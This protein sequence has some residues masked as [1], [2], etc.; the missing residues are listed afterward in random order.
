MD[1]NDESNW[2][3]VERLGSYQ[4]RE[5]VPLDKH[6]QGELYRAKNETSGAT[7]LVFKPAEKDGAVP[8]T[9]WQVR[10][11]SS[12]SPGYLALEVEQT[13]W[14]VA[15]D[16][17]STETLVCTLEDV[18]A[19]VR[20]MAQAVSASNEPRH[21]RHLGW[22][23]VGVATACALGFALVRMDSECPPPS[24]PNTL[25]SAPAP[26][27]HEATTDTWMPEPFTSG[28]LA[29]TVPPG[30]P[31]FARPM[32][33]EPFKGQKRPPCTRLVEVEI[34]GACW[35]PHELKAPCPDELYEYQGKCYLPMF[36]A[37]KP[38]PQSLGQ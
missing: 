5:Q 10:C 33:R 24:D 26:M 34:M 28:W 9:D 15:P 23:M 30:Q 17:Q 19:G 27:S 38:V 7:A 8:R 37:K 11:V 16:K 4:L 29:D 21:W 36:S 35:G 25:T 2:E 12:A 1:E 22:A 3:E 6:S 13:P 20:R 31:V 18:L 32:P 14:S